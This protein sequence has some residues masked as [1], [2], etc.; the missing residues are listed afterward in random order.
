[1]IY[2]ETNQVTRI[3]D[4][5]RISDLDLSSR[6]I[7]FSCTQYDEF[8]TTAVPSAI[9]R[10]L[11]ANSFHEKPVRVKSV[12]FF[13]PFSLSFFLWGSLLMSRAA[14]LRHSRHST[15]WLRKSHLK[16]ERTNIDLA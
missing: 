6:I 11:K 3:S 1:M 7:L 14:S 8:A 4:S 10:V 2:S 12:F 5:A 16:P 15:S 9:S 13:L